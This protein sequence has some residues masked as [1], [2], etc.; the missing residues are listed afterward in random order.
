MISAF[1]TTTRVSHRWRSSGHH[2]RRSLFIPLGAVLA[3]AF[4]GGCGQDGPE[5]VIV[6]GTVTYREKPLLVG[7][8]RFF[9]TGEIDAPVSGAEIM[10]GKYRVEMH[11]GVPVGE[12][13]VSIK[14]FYFDTP[15]GP[16]YTGRPQAAMGPFRHQ[17][18][19][20]K[21]NSDT[22]LSLRIKSASDT[23]TKDYALTD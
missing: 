4:L 5:R 10:D 23:I 6:T 14:G 18:L 22:G 8:I 15:E 3:A 2:M 1:P 16:S 7:E 20:A 11:G 17:Y 12:H 9:P 21:Y 19:P 13:K